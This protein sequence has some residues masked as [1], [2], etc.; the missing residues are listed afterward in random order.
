M[1]YIYIYIYIHTKF[2]TKNTQMFIKTISWNSI[3]VELK[4]NNLNIP[5]RTVSIENIIIIQIKHYMHFPPLDKEQH[6][7]LRNV[8][9]ILFV[10]TS[11]VYLRN[12]NSWIPKSAKNFVNYTSCF[13]MV[14]T[15]RTISGKMKIMNINK[16]LFF[17]SMNVFISVTLSSST[18]T[19]LIAMLFPF[20]CQVSTTCKQLCFSITPKFKEH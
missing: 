12:F 16:K 2:Y 15:G 3:F 5:C 1:Y 11:T 6:S 10:Y 7:T 9:R 17:V 4:K 14:I 19:I 20:C 18:E 8:T 13:I